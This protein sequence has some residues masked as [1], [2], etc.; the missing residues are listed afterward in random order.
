MSI[1]V[2]ALGIFFSK[3]FTFTFRV[4]NFVF[5]TTSLSTTSLSTIYYYF[6]FKSAITVFNLPTAKSSA[7]ALNYDLQVTSSNP[8]LRSSNSRVTS[9]NPRVRRLKARVARSKLKQ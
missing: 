8:R 1:K 5:L 4:L 2:V 7:F 6:F 9:S 3:I